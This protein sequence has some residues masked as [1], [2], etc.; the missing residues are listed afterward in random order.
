MKQIFSRN[1]ILPIAQL[2]IFL[3]QPPI[4]HTVRIL[5]NLRLRNI[6]IIILDTLLK[7]DSFFHDFL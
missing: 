7:N 6:V 5:I 4:L 1:M 3:Y 2:P